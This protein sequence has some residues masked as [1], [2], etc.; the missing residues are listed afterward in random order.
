M[1]TIRLAMP[2]D[3]V[4]IAE[5]YNQGIEDRGAT[6]ET[7]L[8]TPDDIAPRLVEDGPYPTLVATDGHP[9]LGWASLSSAGRGHRRARHRREHVRCV[10]FRRPPSEEAE[11][12]FGRATCRQ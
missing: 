5:I 8:R 9:V 10:L 7:V 4:A 1:T 3:A 2:G 6:F 11:R 12:C